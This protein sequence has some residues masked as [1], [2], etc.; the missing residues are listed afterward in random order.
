MRITGCSVPPEETKLDFVNAQVIEVNQCRC[1]RIEG[2]AV[3]IDQLPGRITLH[4]K[5]QVIVPLRGEAGRK[6]I[7]GPCLGD[8]R[9]AS[10]G[11]E[12]HVL[13]D[14]SPA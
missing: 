2:V 4:P 1:A 8:A 13:V 9:R 6:E 11:I 12:R 5:L 7:E 10:V 14:S 3:A